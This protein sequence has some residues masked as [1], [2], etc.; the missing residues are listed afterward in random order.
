MLR[1]IA[2]TVG[3]AAVSLLLLAAASVGGARA[4]MRHRAA[5]LE[6]LAREYLDRAL[7][8]DS[9]GVAAL[10]LDS[11]AA[12]HILAAARLSP[13]EL[14]LT[15]RSMRLRSAQ[16]SDST[17]M[18]VYATAAKVCSPFGGPDVFQFQWVRSGGGWRVQ[19]ASVPPC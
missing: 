3:I 16:V 6:P 12:H 4:W 10:S 17:A 13:A 8:G 14:A 9:A 5:P 2:R 18:V 1:R 15:R 19:Y 11:A 7:Q